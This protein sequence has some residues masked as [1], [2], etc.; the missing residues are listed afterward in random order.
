MKTLLKRLSKDELKRL[1]QAMNGKKGDTIYIHQLSGDT[2]V[3]K[4][5]KI[6]KRPVDN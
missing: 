5:V 4:L 3:W 1:Q 6:E 2:F